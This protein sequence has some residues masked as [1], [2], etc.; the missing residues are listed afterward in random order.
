ME[1]YE[2]YLVY[3]YLLPFR[4]LTSPG[5]IRV[6]VQRSTIIVPMTHPRHLRSLQPLQPSRALSLVANVTTSVAVRMTVHNALDV[7]Q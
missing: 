2:F 3:L 1:W 7:P 6:W 5:K 4:V